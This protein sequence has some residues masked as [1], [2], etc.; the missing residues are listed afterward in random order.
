MPY[1]LGMLIYYRKQNGWEYSGSQL[2]TEKLVSIAWDSSPATGVY[3]WPEAME[4]VNAEIASGSKDH[5]RIEIAGASA[6]AIRRAQ[7]QKRR[8]P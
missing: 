3:T 8:T 2:P 5:Y 4:I 7:A 1:S 6:K